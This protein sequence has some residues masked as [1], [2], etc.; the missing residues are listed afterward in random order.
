MTSSAGTR[1]YST[2]VFKE[3]RKRQQAAPP[4]TSKSESCCS[5]YPTVTSQP[6][7]HESIKTSQVY[8]DVPAVV[9]QDVRYQSRRHQI[10]S[11]HHYWIVTSPVTQ[12]VPNQSRRHHML[13]TSL[14]NQDIAGHSRRHQMFKT[15]PL[16]H[17]ITSHQS[18]LTRY[19]S[20]KTSSFTQGFIMTPVI[21][22]VTLHLR[23]PPPI[24]ANPVKQDAKSRPKIHGL[25][26]RHQS[27]TKILTVKTSSVN[28]DITGQLKTPPVTMPSQFNHDTIQPWRQHST[29][30]STFDHTVTVQSWRH[31]STT[32][33]PVS[34]DVTSQSW[35]NQSIMTSPNFNKKNH[36]SS[37][38]GVIIHS[39][40][41]KS[42]RRVG[43]VLGNY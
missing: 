42:I 16:N 29:M 34:H 32:T 40:R 37:T 20:N 9:I 4:P 22:G 13:K 3:A 5:K 26:W 25:P 10:Y 15:S 7:R 43:C 31:H 41:K 17:D 28:A 11:R 24:M 39:R 21:Q 1:W 38:L 14:L 23:R 30:T 36:Q 8:R 6:R 27:W 33:S 2:F 35:R 12:D 18:L 19:D